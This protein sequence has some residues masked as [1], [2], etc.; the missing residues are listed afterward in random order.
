MEKPSIFSNQKWWVSI[1]M[2]VFGCVII[3]KT[4]HPTLT[5]SFSFS[6][7]ET[8][9]F[10]QSIAIHLHVHVGRVYFTLRCAQKCLH[11]HGCPGVSCDSCKCQWWMILD[12]TRTFWQKDQF[13][14][15][16]GTVGAI[17]FLLGGDTWDIQIRT[18]LHI[19]IYIITY[20][21]SSLNRILD[22]YH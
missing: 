17:V 7:A 8:H 6:G 18:Y 9:L 22:R 10:R 3:K 20:T 14:A 1:A 12:P 13:P 11:C 4:T 5:K 15:R 19:H 16:I 2:F 21:S